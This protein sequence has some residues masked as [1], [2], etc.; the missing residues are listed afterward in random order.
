METGVRFLFLR[1][2]WRAFGSRWLIAASLAL[3]A[4]AVPPPLSPIQRTA[5]LPAQAR[6]ELAT[7]QGDTLKFFVSNLTDASLIISR[8]AIVMSSSQGVRNRKPG[9]VANMY[10]LAPKGIHDVNVRFSFEG[11]KAGE[12]VKVL[13]DRAL[14]LDGH[15]L[16]MPPI[17]LRVESAAQGGARNLN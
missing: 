5:E 14:L 9:G 15:P 1:N 8:D 10:L 11:V 16:P 2:H 13:F 12:T 17:S 6:V 3:V 4:C 7:T